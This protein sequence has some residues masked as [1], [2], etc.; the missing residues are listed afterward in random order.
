MSIIRDGHHNRLVAEI[1]A[2]LVEYDHEHSTE[3]YVR[4]TKKYVQQQAK[5]VL[6]RMYMDD[7]DDPEQCDPATEEGDYY[8]ESIEEYGTLYT[9]YPMD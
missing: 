5:M 7:E 4:P 1:D 2:Y 3:N 6:E 8:R 9:D